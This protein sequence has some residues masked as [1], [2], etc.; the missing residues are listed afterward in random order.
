MPCQVQHVT[1]NA[2]QVNGTPG[3]PV[4]NVRNVVRK[5]MAIH[6]NNSA[7]KSKNGSHRDRFSNAKKIENALS[8]IN[9]VE[10]NDVV[11]CLESSGNSECAGLSLVSKALKYAAGKV[12]L[13]KIRLVID[14]TK[15]K[16]RAAQT[17]KRLTEADRMRAFDQQL[18]CRTLSTTNP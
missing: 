17:H 8:S 9:D 16:T 3:N 4:A 12:Q 10:A 11:L 13:N 5:T 15:L 6:I 7:N 2:D 18:Q 14:N 1:P